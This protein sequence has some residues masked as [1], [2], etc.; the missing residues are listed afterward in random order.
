MNNN[1]GLHHDYLANH[2]RNGKN[3][4]MVTIFSAIA[5]MSPYNTLIQDLKSSSTQ[6]ILAYTG[7]KRS[8]SCS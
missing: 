2:F 6:F 7:R 5:N 3:E 1:I 8:G 4:E